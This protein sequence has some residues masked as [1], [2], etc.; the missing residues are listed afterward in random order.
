LAAHLAFLWAAAPG[1]GAITLRY[2]GT[3]PHSIK[4]K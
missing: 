2:A 1:D 3:G 4:L